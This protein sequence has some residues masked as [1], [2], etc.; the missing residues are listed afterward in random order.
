VIISRKSNT[1]QEENTLGKDHPDVLES[2]N[3]L[4]VLYHE[5]SRAQDSELLLLEAVR[6]RRLKLGD[7]HPH[8]LKSWNHRI[9]L[10]EAWNKPKKA[11]EWRAN[12]L[13]TE[14]VKSDIKPESRLFYELKDAAQIWGHLASILL[15]QIPIFF[16]RVPKNTNSKPKTQFEKNL[17]GFIVFN[18][19]RQ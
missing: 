9:E 7:S 10:Y 8:T 18:E 6:H 13:E 19:R 11:K 2:K 3:D 15:P 5:L 17:S 14:A 16:I 1:D 12:I 4:G